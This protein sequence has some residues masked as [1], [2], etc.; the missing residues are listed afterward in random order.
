MLQSGKVNYWTGEDV[1]NFE[2]A[3][4]DYLGVKHAVAVTNGTFALEAPLHALGIG[5]GD[6]VLVPSRT[7]L[8]SASSVVMCGAKPIMVDVDPVSQNLTVATI[9]KALTPKTKAIIAVHLAGWPCEMDEIMAFAK[10]N[11]LFVIEDCA[12]AHGAEYKGKKAGS[13]GH[14]AA[15]SFCQDK[16]MSTGGEGGMIVTNNTDLWQKIWS[17]KDHGKSYD[18]VFNKKHPPG[19]RWLHDSFGTNGRMTGMQAAI[20]SIQLKKLPAWLQHR[21]KLVQLMNECLT[22]LPGLRLSMPPKDVSHASYKYYVFVE[23]E[24]LAAGW[25]RDRIMQELQEQGVTCF[26]GS[27]SEVYLEKAFENRSWALQ[28]RLPVAQALG[29]ASL[30]FL[31]DPT[32]TEEDAKKAATVLKH[33]MLE[34]QR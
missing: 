16:I 18:T 2:K 20:G 31:V 21:Q 30:M 15:F 25:H 22:G 12:Q 5:P 32:V 4:A 3:F 24:C 27:C 23:P 14:V 13:L 26:S 28:K 33:I 9:E 11:D 7:F 17:F 34:A 6:E 19:F 29:E 10:A 8:A 1:K